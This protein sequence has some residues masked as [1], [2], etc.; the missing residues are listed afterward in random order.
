MTEMAFI[1][2][3]QAWF[4]VRKLK[5][6]NI[7]RIKGNSDKIIPINIANE[8]DKIQHLFIMKILIKLGTEDSLFKL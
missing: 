1:A 8:F 2:R 3:T 4:N 5:Q 7:K 6:Y